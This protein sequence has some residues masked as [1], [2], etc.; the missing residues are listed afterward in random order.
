MA[1][2]TMFSN[3]T[4]Q[5]Y[6]LYRKGGAIN[7]MSSLCWSIV[8]FV[9]KGGRIGVAGREDKPHTHPP[10]KDSPSPPLGQQGTCYSLLPGQSLGVE[11]GGG[12]G[13]RQPERGVQTRKHHLPPSLFNTHQRTSASC[14]SSFVTLQK[15]SRSIQRIECSIILHMSIGPSP[16]SSIPNSHQHHI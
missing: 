1:Y 13:K 2:R 7:L 14:K 4:L 11:R 8:C 16:L 3:A 10:Y 6:M 15:K 5:I 9:Y 12:G